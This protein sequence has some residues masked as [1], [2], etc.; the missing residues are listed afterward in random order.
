[1]ISRSRTTK[2][3]NTSGGETLQVAHSRFV[4]PPNLPVIS[5]QPTKNHSYQLYTADDNYTN[6]IARFHRSH[7][8][9]PSKLVANV[10]AGVLDSTPTL[11]NP[12]SSG[13][14]PAVLELA[15]RAMEI[16]DLVVTSFLFLEKSRRTNENNAVNVTRP[17]GIL[18]TAC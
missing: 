4:F 9:P 3:R 2:G 6:T 14:T 5:N 18:S 7:R 15:P 16:Q 13:K 10:T 11:V 1:M 17:V 8:I 12:P